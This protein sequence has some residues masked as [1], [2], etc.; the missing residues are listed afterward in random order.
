[1]VQVDVPAA[2]GVGCVFADAAR[3]QLQA[4]EPHALFRVWVQHNVYQTFFFAWIPIYFLANYFGWETT[5]MWWHRDSVADYP[6]YLPLFLLVFFLAANSGFLLGVAL[7]RARRI[8]LVRGIYLGI[9]T[10]SAIWILA[11]LHNTAKLGS[12]AQWRAGQAPWF[13]QDKRFLFM[14]IFVMIL[15]MSGLG[16]FYVKLYREGKRAS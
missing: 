6:L 16:G 13:W 10:A 3:R 9:L 5:H 4:G 8:K 14:L 15:W 1:M 7:V 11:Q 2:F 12:Y